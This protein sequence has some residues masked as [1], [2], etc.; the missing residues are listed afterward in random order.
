MDVF[1]LVY[2]LFCDRQCNI[3]S[4]FTKQNYLC[5]SSSSYSTKQRLNSVGIHTNFVQYKQ[6]I[7]L[8]TFWWVLHAAWH[9][10]H[11]TL[12][13]LEGIKTGGTVKWIVKEILTSQ[14]SGLQNLKTGGSVNWIL[15]E[16]LW[17]VN[18]FVRSAMISWVCTWKFVVFSVTTLWYYLNVIFLCKP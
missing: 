1:V 4:L 13:N 3:V 6:I 10:I 15:T 9:S 18:N 7:L 2:A 8:C 12:L 16:S 14:N 5:I 17:V 11:R